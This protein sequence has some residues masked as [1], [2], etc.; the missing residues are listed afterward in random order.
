MFMGEFAHALDE[1]GRLFVPTPLRSGL[2]ER[3]VVTRG[4][5]ASLFFF[6][7]ADWDALAA[8][9]Q[10]LPLGRGD[11]RSLARYLF[12]GAQ[13]LDTDSKGR[14]LL[15]AHLRAHAGIDREAVWIGVGT[16]VELWAQETW[17]TYSDVARDRF[18]ALA[19]GLSDVG[20]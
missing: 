4:F 3:F 17:R 9:L 15:P 5:D 19:E 16:R 14:V 8:R 6:T 2:G 20:L 11:A 18:E 13:T 7:E 10:S 12:S 1:K